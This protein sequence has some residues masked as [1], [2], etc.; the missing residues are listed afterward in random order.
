MQKTI[1]LLTLL[2]FTWGTNAQTGVPYRVGNKFGVSDANGKML[3]APE[4]DV[5]QTEFF[6]VPYMIGY[7]LSDTIVLSTLIYKNKIILKDQ[8]YKHYYFYND[9]FVAH[10]YK[11][12]TGKKRWDDKPFVETSQ[13][14]TTAGKRVLMGDFES[15]SIVT[16]FDEANKLNEVLVYTRDYNDKTSLLIYDKRT[17]KITKTVIP[18]TDY[19]RVPEHLNYDYQDKSITYV[20]K[21]SDG[22]GKQVNFAAGKGVIAITEQGTVDLQELQKRENQADDGFGFADV[23]MPMPREKPVKAAQDGVTRKVKLDLEFYYLPQKVEKI[24][25]T[26]DG[27]KSDYSHI[28]TK[29]GKKGLVITESEKQIIPAR[30]D[31]ILEAEFLDSRTGGYILRNATKYGLFM[32]VHPN[33]TIIEPVFS[34]MPL[35]DNMNYFGVN[36]P[37]IRLYDS[38]GKFF[39]YADGK[40]K[41]FYTAK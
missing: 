37:L 9:L 8:P 39:C 40:G 18:A 28:I 26:N 3:I 32:D 6:N 14:F 17:Q 25:V 36:A 10:A 19:L 13:L 11:T 41:L 24:A 22:T 1:L 33:P 35:L 27:F 5:L 16:E 30:F 34:Y 31:E 21:A 29:A 7:R 38:N 2:I 4:F 12:R 23:A 15:I 20:Y